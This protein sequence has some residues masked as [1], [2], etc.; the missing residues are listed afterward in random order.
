MNF[1]TYIP[2]KMQTDILKTIKSQNKKLI[3]SLTYK[4]NDNTKESDLKNFIGE[5]W[6]AFKFETN[7]PKGAVS[8]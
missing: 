6:N 8:I 1:Q 2:E 4:Y 7:Q 5:K 3:Q